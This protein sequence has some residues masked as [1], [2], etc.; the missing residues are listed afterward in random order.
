MIFLLQPS[1]SIELLGSFAFH[2]ILALALSREHRIE[3]IRIV[4][5]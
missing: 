4:F 3:E 5:V 1:K 2:G